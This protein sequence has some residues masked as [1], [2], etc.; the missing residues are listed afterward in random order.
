MDNELIKVRSLAHCFKDAYDLFSTNIGSIIR[1]TWR[2]A[3]A[4]AVLSAL[5]M[6]FML[7]WL[8]AIFSSPVTP[9]SLWAAVGAILGSSIAILGAMIWFNSVVIGMLNAQR[10][11]FNLK[12]QTRLYLSFAAIIVIVSTIATALSLL[13]MYIGTGISYGQYLLLLTGVGGFLFIVLWIGALPIVYSSTKY[14]MEPDQKLRSVLGRPYLNGWRHWGYLFLVALIATIIYG[15]L[16]FVASMPLTILRLAFMQNLA[17]LTLGDPSGLPGHFQAVVF[18]ST[19]LC[20][21]IWTYI[22]T[23]VLMVFYHAYGHVEAKVR[24]R[25]PNATPSSPTL[26]DE[27]PPID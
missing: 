14:L 25:N 21:V 20:T 3:L 8:I 15:L 24:L 19:L 1:K 17:G 16:Y 7:P 18:A 23:W 6:A 5:S 10:L 27:F 13:P 22:Q 2:P 4:I 11:A 9:S 12:R 26:T